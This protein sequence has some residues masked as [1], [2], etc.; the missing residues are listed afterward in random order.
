MSPINVNE[1][2]LRRRIQIVLSP[3]AE[4]FNSLHVL[5][6]PE[7][8]LSNQAWSAEMMEKM[9][10]E[11]KRDIAYFGQYFEQWLTIADLMSLVQEPALSLEAFL[12][13][14]STL[15]PADVVKVA[16]YGLVDEVTA[17]DHPPLIPQN[18]VVQ[19]VHKQAMQA[20]GEFVARLSRT[21]RRYWEDIFGAEWE[22][23][24]P[25][26]DQYRAQYAM[27]LDTTDPPQWLTTLHSRISY[28]R[29][30]ERLTFHKS[31]D[32]HFTLADLDRILCFPSSFTAPHLM[33]GFT[34]KELFIYI[35]VPLTMERPER[36]PAELLGVAKALAD[37]T[38]LRIF[39]L[40]LRRPH[41][42]QEIAAL[43]KLAEPTVSKHLKVLKSAH[44]VHS[45]KEGSFV[46]YAGSLDAIDRLPAVMRDF[47]R[48]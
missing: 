14:L 30:L 46:L 7:H 32:L 12:A 19:A 26:L 48:S 3:V 35:N 29:E 10:P 38:R 47:I 24:Y 44:L 37:E 20:P 25:L 23:R 8:H 41:Y 6:E 11:L 15:N 4:M 17:A 18:E 33:V 31:Q 43:I 1:E 34:Q 27:R 9:D 21:L 13:F 42:T 16:L 36:V 22:R 2:P 39:K 45:Y 40:V 28:N 5:A